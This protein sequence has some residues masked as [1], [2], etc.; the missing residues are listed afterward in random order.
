MLPGNSP[1]ANIFK[2]SQFICKFYVGSS[3]IQG[4]GKRRQRRWSFY[5]KALHPT[6]EWTWAVIIHDC[7]WYYI[8]THRFPFRLSGKSWASVSFAAFWTKTKTFCGKLPD[9]PSTDR[10]KILPQ[11]RSPK[12]WKA[13]STLTCGFC[14]LAP[15]APPQKTAEEIKILFS[16]TLTDVY[17][18]CGFC[19]LRYCLPLLNWA[20]AKVY[21]PK[22]FFLLYWTFFELWNCFLSKATQWSFQGNF[23]KRSMSGK[24]TSNL[25]WRK[26]CW[27]FIVYFLLSSLKL[28]TCW[29]TWNE[30]CVH[31]P[32]NVVAISSAT[33]R[34]QLQMKRNISSQAISV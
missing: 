5:T 22:T 9:S 4:K 20:K 3:W 18:R 15:S 27:Q 25:A 17:F 29:M 33:F 23:M 14:Y 11:Q 21:I 24:I 1:L 34:A 26:K 31:L 6:N 8:F 19:T 13:Q 30:I 2:N 16:A 7:R 28:A 12:W 10:E 32:V